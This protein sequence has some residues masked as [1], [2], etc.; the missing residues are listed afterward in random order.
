MTCRNYA[1]YDPLGFCN[2]LKSNDFKSVFESSAYE[3]LSHLKFILQQYI[4]KH[5]PIIKTR[6]KG[7]LCPWFNKER[8]AKN[9]CEGSIA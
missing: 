5:A 9:E 8:K 4:D 6:M 1:N 7:K 3:A 2:D